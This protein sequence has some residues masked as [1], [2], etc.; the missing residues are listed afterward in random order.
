MRRVGFWVCS[1]LVFSSMVGTGVFTSLGFQAAVLSSPFVILALWV[2]GGVVALCGAL[3][4]AELA[5]ALPR[6][7]GEYH[8]LS[9]IF[10][11]A[12]GVMAGVVSVFVGFSAP[13]ALGAMAF[14]SYFSRAFPGVPPGVSAPVV[15]VGLALVHG[16]TLGVSG[17]FQVAAT[18]CKVTLIVGFLVAGFFL[19]EGAD[20]RPARGDMM[21]VASPAFAVSLMFVMYSYSGWNSAVYIAGEVQNPERVLPAA[22]TA[23]TLV[24][25]LLYV[26]LNAVFLASAPLSELQG[27]IEIG[28]VAARHL[29]GV[30]GGRLMSGIIAAGLIAALSALTWA[31]PRVAQVAGEDFR[32]LSWFARKSGTGIPVQALAFQTAVVMVLLA[33]GSFEAVLLY[34]QFALMTCSC[35]TIAGMLVL[36]W[37]EPKLPRPFLC[38]LFPWP[39]LAFLAVGLFSLVYTVAVRPVQ[40]GAGILTLAAGV[41]LYFFVRK[42]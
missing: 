24:V 26:G 10:H 21:L 42:K 31:G 15:V 16:L 19:A 39:P 33:S 4:Y 17:R 34:A 36:R 5:A 32:E 38:P 9:R 30:S 20:F 41:C 11:P 12:F 7:G 27:K 25:T 29:F 22:L 2:V 28:E 8:F 6:S 40:A 3:S 23:G 35:L 18:V 37:R 14:G 1:A 13:L